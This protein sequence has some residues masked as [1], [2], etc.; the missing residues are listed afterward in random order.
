LTSLAYA[1]RFGDDSEETG[2]PLITDRLPVDGTT[3]LHWI[4]TEKMA[5][6]CLTK[7]MKAGTLE[8]VMNGGWM[9]FT[10]EKEK[11]CENRSMNEPD[12]SSIQL[13][14]S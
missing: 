4:C 6:D 9:D 3:R 7:A 1:N 13:V 8:G 2:D 12:D 10:P 14:T 11:E 5:A